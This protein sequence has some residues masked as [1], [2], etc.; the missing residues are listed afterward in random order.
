MFS[1]SYV[2]LDS[3]K[4]YIPASVEFCGLTET[5]SFLT[6]M[7]FNVVIEK[8]HFLCLALVIVFLRW[9]ID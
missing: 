8:P 5:N 9:Q 4:T 2:N 1:V 7:I 6:P 3:D